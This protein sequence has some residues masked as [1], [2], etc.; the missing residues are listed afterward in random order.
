MYLI[1]TTVLFSA[2]AANVVAA[3][4]TGQV[5]LSEVGAFLL[6]LATSLAFVAAMLRAERH[7]AKSPDMDE[8]P[9]AL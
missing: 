1:I 9:K 8:G 6:L 7:R 3:A 4:L 2:F 5:F